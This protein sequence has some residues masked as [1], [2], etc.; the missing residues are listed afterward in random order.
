MRGGALIV[1]V[2]GIVGR[3]R[4]LIGI[5]EKL[6]LEGWDWLDRLGQKTVEENGE[7]KPTASFMEEII[8]GRPVFSFPNRPG[9][10]R[11]RYGRARTTGLAAVGVHPAIMVVANDSCVLVCSS[12]WSY[13]VSQRRFVL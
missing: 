10:F 7:K 11:L 1:I 5:T 12:G 3:A 13:Q 6:G 8:V 9:G 2:D 4:K